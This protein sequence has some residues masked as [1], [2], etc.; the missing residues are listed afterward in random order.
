M[1]VLKNDCL[2]IIL[3]WGLKVI[4]KVTQSPPGYVPVC[5]VI[6][7]KEKWVHIDDEK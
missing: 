4:H 6:E 7:I 1:K 3:D 5:T 2:F